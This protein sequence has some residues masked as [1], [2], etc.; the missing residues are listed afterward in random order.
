M[1]NN[2]NNIKNPVQDSGL[3]AKNKKKKYSFT[4]IT[5]TALIIIAVIILNVIMAVLADRVSLNVDLTKDS[6]LSFSDTTKK[7]VAELDTNIKI[8]SL[9]PASDETRE[10]IQIDEILKK[11]DIMSDKI[12]YTRVD[13]KK[14]PAM[15]TRYELDGEALSNDYH[16]IFESDKTYTVVNIQDFLTKY[17]HNNKKNMILTGAL[18]AEQYFTSA[19][20]KVS[21]GGDVNIYVLA[22]HNE[23]FSAEDFRKR[24]MPGSGVNFKDITLISEDIPDNADM[25]IAA[26]PETDY[27]E[28]EISKIDAYMRDGG[29]MKV[30]ADYNSG[31]LTNF[32]SYLR[33]WGVTFEDGIAADNNTS[34]YAEGAKINIIANVAENEITASM[35]IGSN[36]LM[37]LLARPIKVKETVN[38]S[39]NIIATTSDDGY[40]KKDI[41]SGV[42]S[43]EQGDVKA[44]SNLAV[45]LRRQ[46]SVDNVSNMAVFSTS[47]FFGS[48]NN[49]DFSI[50]DK[51]GN[52]TL[53]TGLVNYMTEQPTVIIAPK[54]IYQGEIVVSQKSIYVYTVITALLI[55]LAILSSGLII[56]LRRRHS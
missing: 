6:I 3:N 34:S 33:E 32:Y 35:G 44:K 36:N 23:K 29:D 43:F 12:S 37:F 46:N 19:I 48:Y 50:L 11:Y 41:S 14:N 5:S 7:I 8:M 40:I 30:I 56:W 25:I 49:K 42:D 28:G 38:T 21:V 18:G 24:I 27:S 54:N 55:P 10:V 53:I 45:V 4:I 17:Y 52:R 15:L 1:D 2:K 9:I 26:S 13:T 16:I 47:Y 39:C 22:G 20:N 51:T 31:N